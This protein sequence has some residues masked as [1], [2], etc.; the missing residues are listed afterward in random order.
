M[1]AIDLLLLGLVAALAGIVALWAVS[2]LP[3]RP[4]G[5]AGPGAAP[6]DRAV[7][8]V[9]EG[10][11]SIGGCPAAGLLLDAAPAGSDD[12][13]RLCTL[14]DGRFPGLAAQLA[15]L[16]GDTALTLDGAGDI[17]LRARRDEA[18]L[19][20]TLEPATEPAA[21]ATPGPVAEVLAD[22]VARMRAVIAACPVPAW[23]SGRDGAVTWANAAYHDA[24]GL[25]SQGGAGGAPGQLPALVP[26]PAAACGAPR[27]QRSRPADGGQP[28]WFDRVDR[29]DGR[30]GLTCFALPAEDLV[31]AEA[32]LHGTLQTLTG[33][34][35]HLPIGLAIFDTDR[36]LSLFNPVLS[37]LT[38]LPPAFLA[39]RP[40]LHDMLDR[41][42]DL[43]MIPEP[44]DYAGWRR[45]LADIE[46][47]AGAGYYTELWPL[48]SGQTYRVTG[49]PDAAGGIALLFENITDETARNRHLKS[50]ADLVAAAVAA[51]DRAVA[52]FD[53]GGRA[54]LQ[55]PAYLALWRLDP[56]AADH[57]AAALGHWQARCRPTPVWDE[58]RRSATAPGPRPPRDVAL[59]LRDGRALT[60]RFRQLPGRATM[61]EFLPTAGPGRG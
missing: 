26:E 42:R 12:L 17:R 39:R 35:A 15:T 10:R 40:S 37:D 19:R 38:G 50:R 22:E 1:T 58:L 28:R 29:P 60:G 54:V 57:C 52:I 6:R 32:A 53:A 7:E 4:H 21:R 44:R 23:G 25:G 48:P 51:Q 34:F 5:A 14:L 31:R 49:Q 41:L 59:A 20:L 30:G 55:T 24:L 45:R 47:A 8:L 9:F 46:R 2:R 33:A 36:R 13:H 61:A 3:A 27:R 56:G 43:R 16:S 11:A 18:R